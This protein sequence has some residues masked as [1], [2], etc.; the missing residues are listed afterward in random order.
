VAFNLNKTFREVF[1]EDGVR[2]ALMVPAFDLQRD[3]GAA[4][5]RS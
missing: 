4:Q 5:S 3:G 1:V 2:A